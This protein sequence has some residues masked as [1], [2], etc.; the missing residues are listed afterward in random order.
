V[1]VGLGA[2]AAVALERRGDARARGPDGDGGLHGDDRPGLQAGAHVGEDGVE[3]APVGSRVGVDD[4]RRHGDD[5]VRALGHGLGGLRRGP[6]ATGAQRVPE[7]L[8]EARLPGE[9][10]TTGVDELDGVGV[11]I[12]ADDVVACAGDLDGQWEP[13]LAER[14]DDGLHAAACSATVSPEAALASTASAQATA[15]RPSASVTTCASG[16]PASRSTKP[17]S[18]TSSGSRRARA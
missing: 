14:D 4:E 2:Q 12:A 5:E 18:S 9:R 11:D 16:T 8:V 10:R 6:Q 15:S 17:S 7:R 1:E 3:R 13:D